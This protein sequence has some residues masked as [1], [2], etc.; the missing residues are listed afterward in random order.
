MWTCDG[1]TWTQRC[2]PRAPG[3]RVV[4]GL[5]FDE[6]RGVL[7]LFGGHDGTNVL[8]DLWEYSSGG[9]WQK[10][11]LPGEPPA[12]AAAFMA[13][14]RTRKRTVIFGG[15]DAA[16]VV[17][18]DVYEYDGKAW[19][20]PLTA[21]GPGPR[22]NSGSGAAFVDA[23]ALVPAMRD[24]VVIFGGSSTADDDSPNDECWAWDGASWTSI[25]TAC[26]KLPR[27][28]AALVYDPATGRAVSINGWGGDGVWEIAGTIEHFGNAWLGSS[29]LPGIRDTAGAAFDVKRNRIVDY[30]GNGESC[31]SG[32]VGANCDETL[33]F[34]A[35]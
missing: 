1:T 14:D 31:G 23:R 24:R 22:N 6:S 30:G 28:A 3:P 13:Y 7:V 27:T 19:Y 9:P 21:T 29:Q 5:V 25:C 11:T 34:V 32:S 15:V 33:E 20:G 18:G 16:G 17:K 26:T 4:H 10:I 8:G 12:R 35:P 2:S